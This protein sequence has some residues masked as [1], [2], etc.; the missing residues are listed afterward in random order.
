MVLQLCLA[1]QTILPWS[2]RS[3]CKRNRIYLHFNGI[4]SKPLLLPDAIFI[5]SPG[6]CEANKAYMKVKCA[7]SCQ[8]C[9]MIDINSR[10]PPLDG[11]VRP[12]FLPGEMNSMFERIV[13]T[14]PGNQTEGSVE[15]AEGMTNYSVH[16][17][18]RPE[19]YEGEPIIST[20]HDMR[21]DPWVITVSSLVEKLYNALPYLIVN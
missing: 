15:I 19:P 16:V 10:C 9:H 3:L 1:R 13:R 14:A 5:L 6:E 12:G 8:S 20:E 7:P 11:D 2:K 21:N 17:H 18:S 4:S